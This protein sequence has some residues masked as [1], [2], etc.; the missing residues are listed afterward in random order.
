MDIGGI[1]GGWALQDI[2]RLGTVGIFGDWSLKSASSRA[3][4]SSALKSNIP[5][6]R[7]EKKCLEMRSWII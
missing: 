7:G 3:R 5:I 1:L 4:I 2:L 6:A